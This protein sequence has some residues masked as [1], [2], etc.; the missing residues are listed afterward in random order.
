MTTLV[1]APTYILEQ[2]EVIRA[3]RISGGAIVSVTR[4]DGRLHRHRVGLR[5]Y[6]RLI[7][8]LVSHLGVCGGDFTRRGFECQ[9]R[10]VRG[11]ADARRWA[12]RH[13]AKYWREAA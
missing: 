5:R 6:N 9:L 13:R 3:Y 10:E 8:T 2:H 7:D 11:L 12:A 1:A 4:A